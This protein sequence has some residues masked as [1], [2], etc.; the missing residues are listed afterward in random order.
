MSPTVDNSD[1]IAQNH[2]RANDELLVAAAQSGDPLAFAELKD[3]HSLR[4]RR[5]LYR[6]TRNW[7]DAEDALQDCFFKVFTHLGGFGNR[8]SFGTWLTSIA[9]NSGLTVLRKRRVHREVPIDRDD[10]GFKS[11]GRW[12]L[13]DRTE[14]PETYCVR[15]ER[16]ELLRRAILRLRPDHRMLVELQK[17]HDYSMKELSEC[18]GISLP[19][20]KSRLLRARKALRT[21]LRTKQLSNLPDTRVS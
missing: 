15:R 7:D 18:L 3:R 6:I 5:L 1:T 19:A 17:T 20:V 9:I 12:E 14:D 21:S 2:K 13:R 11:R 10:D 8:S 16:E 4:T